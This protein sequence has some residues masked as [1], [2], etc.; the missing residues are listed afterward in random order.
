MWD[1]GRPDYE[2][3]KRRMAVF[4]QSTC[5]RLQASFQT[6]HPQPSPKGGDF[7]DVSHGPRA[8]FSSFQRGGPLA[9]ASRSRPAPP[10]SLVDVVRNN[11]DDKATSA[12]SETVPAAAFAGVTRGGAH[13][14][15]GGVS[16][17]SEPY[18]QLPERGRK[19]LCR[20][21]LMQATRGFGG[22]PRC[23]ERLLK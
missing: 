22:S 23:T 19:S 14:D 7:S 13:G 11:G 3:A 5:N 21:A 4:L 9:R 15:G 1:V 20:R 12:T 17:V 18:A 10:P 6:P 8:A 16:Y 2:R